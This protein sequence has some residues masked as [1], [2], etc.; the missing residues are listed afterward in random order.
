MGRRAPRRRAA[1][2]LPGLSAVDDAPPS[3]LVGRA[4][5]REAIAAAL[6]ALP[7]QPGTV[8]AL[9]GEPGIGKSRLLEHLAA[10]AEAERRVGARGAR[11]GVRERPSVRAVDRGARRSPRRAWASAGCPGWGSRIPRRSR[12]CCRPWRVARPSREAT[13]TARTGRCATCWSASRRRARSF[14]GWT[15]CTGPTPR[16]S[17]RIAALVRRPPAAPR[18]ARGGGARGPAARSPGSWR[19]PAPAERGA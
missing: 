18:A 8:V 11:L 6:R 19:S 3:G 13:G 1:R 16:R 9:E 7:A 17:T 15:T 14:S 2:P 12:R 4:R 5:E 10:S